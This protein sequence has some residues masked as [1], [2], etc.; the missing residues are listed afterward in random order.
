MKL[1][2]GVVYRREQPIPT[3]A[4]VCT[5]CGKH[6]LPD[7]KEIREEPVQEVAAATAR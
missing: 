1:V 7:P 4:F 5:V 6:I 2:A 3:Y